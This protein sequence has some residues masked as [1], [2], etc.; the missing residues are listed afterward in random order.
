MKLTTPGFVKMGSLGI[1]DAACGRIVDFR[2]DTVTKP[3]DAMRAAMAIAEVGDDVQGGDPTIIQLQDEIAHIMGKEAGLFVSSGT[4]GNLIAVLVHCDTRGSEVIMG[5]ES[6]ISVYEQGGVSTLGGVHPR[7]VP[8]NSDG[9][10]DL[11]KLEAAIRYELDDHYPI[12]R[13][14]CLENTQARCGGRCISAE[15]TDK[16]GELAKSYGLQLHIDGARI[17]NA[18]VELGVA[19]ERLVRA[20]DTVS[21]CLSKGLGAPVGTVLVGSNEFIIKARRLRKALGGGMRQVG[22]LGAAGL[23]ALR[24]MVDRLAVDHANARLMA[25]G[26]NAVK[27]LRVDMGI[28]E[29]NIVYAEVTTE[30][31]LTPKEIVEAWKNYGV[32]TLTWGRTIRVVTHYHITEDDVRFALR[33]FD[34]ISLQKNLECSVPSTQNDTKL[35]AQCC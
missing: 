30:S 33:F 9:T 6:H 21:V 5:T 8:N 29:T 28:V 23:V 18:S 27:G 12:T 4:M 15:Y 13:L 26:L 2:S 10:M 24:D 11:S 32:L 34:T 7:T 3:T 1:S 17:F 25:E 35:A 16:V 31:A 14:I 20:A 22:I 19:P